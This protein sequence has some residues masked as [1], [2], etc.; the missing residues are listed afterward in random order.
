M[1]FRLKVDASAGDAYVDLDLVTP[2][3][4]IWVTLTGVELDTTARNA[5]LAAGG[6]GF[7][8]AISDEPP[9]TFAENNAFWLQDDAGTLKWINWQNV[10]GDEATANDQHTV[11]IRNDGG[12]SSGELYVDGVLVDAAYS[13]SGDARTVRVGHYLGFGNAAGMILFVDAVAIGTTRG[14]DDLF[15]DSFED[16]TLDAWTATEGDVSV[17]SSAPADTA[18]RMGAPPLWRGIVTSQASRTICLL[19]QRATDKVVA[20]ALNQPALASGVA[21]ADDD[22]IHR[23]FPDADSDPNLHPNLR[24]CYLFRYEGGTPPWICRFGGIFFVTEDQG[25]D[26]PVT[27]YTAYDPWQ[28][29]FSRPCLDDG[30]VLPGEEGIVYTNERGSDIALDLIS[31]TIATNGTVFLDITNGELHDTE[32]VPGPGLEFKIE[33]GVS[34]G[35]A[36]QRL[37]DTGT[38]DIIMSPVYDPL[39]RPGIV[40]ELNI[41]EFAGDRKDSAIMAWDKGR[42]SITSISRLLDGTQLANKIQMFAGQ[43]GPAVTPVED[44]DSVAKYGEYWSQQFLVAGKGQ[45][46]LVELFAEAQALIRRDGLR[47]V[48]FDPALERAPLALRDYNLGD[49][50]PVWASRNLRQPIAPDYD[51]ADYDPGFA[52]YLRVYAIPIEI[53]DDGVEQ[54]RRIL[55]S[56]D[57]AG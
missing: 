22:E 37:T 52:G 7:L 29:L 36:L 34:V 32:V 55:T 3:T 45:D 44:V 42:R 2:E 21:P 47:S 46:A 57:A 4:D 49:Y 9:V 13:I 18:V 6:S 16:G 17:V 26:A 50:L 25:T 15:F 11:E 12:G 5:W 48:T 31:K 10:F 27:S 38:M 23:P 30:F 56:Q 1:A 20:F 33:R 54:V 14:D 35:E 39:N 53:R 24:L 19:D 43:G 40:C 28:L 8:A 41:Y 51:L